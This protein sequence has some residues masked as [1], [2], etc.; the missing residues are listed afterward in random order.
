VDIDW[1]HWNGGDHPI[2]AESQGLLDL[3]TD[4]RSGL[5][6][7]SEI[8]LDVAASNW[9]GK[10]YLDGVVDKI[11]YI[12]TM[13]YDLRGPWSEQ[14]PQ[15]AYGEVIDNG[16]TNYTVGSW[17][18]P[19]WNGYRKWPIAKTVIGVPFYGRDFDVNNGEGVDYS[20]IA[21]RVKQAGADINAD[22]IGNA[23]YDG[24]VTAGR[25]AAYALSHNYA[26]VMFWELTGDTQDE[27]T[28]LLSAIDKAIK[29]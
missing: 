14:G 18:L 5:D 23:Y 22:R 17:G 24:P 3:L 4:L 13:L 8:S 1:E 10:H 20:I 12:N 15:S 7:N 25:K 26:G 19:Y 2:A 16:T 9:S 11:T 6:V 29:K 27:T 21:A 28:S